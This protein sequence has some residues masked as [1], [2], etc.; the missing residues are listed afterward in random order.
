MISALISGVICRWNVFH[1]CDYIKV[2]KSIALLTNR[3]F[4]WLL[5][6]KPPPEG[7]F[8]MGATLEIQRQQ[9]MELVEQEMLFSRF[10]EI[11]QRNDLN[12]FPNRRQNDSNTAPSSA[13]PRPLSSAQNS[14][15]NEEKVTTLV[16]MG[17]D[18]QNVVR[19]LQRS[20]NDLN[21]ATNILL[22]ES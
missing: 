4:G 19:A 17:F 15:A 21:L 5:E 12:I 7:P 20:N 6:S 10:R 8:L 16:E 2:P 14:I 13:S 11:N 22:S 9:H 1:I 3:L 18:R